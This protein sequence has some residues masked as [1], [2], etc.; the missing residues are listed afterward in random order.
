MLALG[1]SE[2][3]FIVLKNFLPI[4]SFQS[5]FIMESVGFCQILSYIT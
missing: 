5:V 3:F 2:M 1:F 4:D